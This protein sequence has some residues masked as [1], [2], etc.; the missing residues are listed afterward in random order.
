L[1][2]AIEFFAGR[3]GYSM[4]KTVQQSC[5]V[6][7]EHLG[8]LLDRIEATTDRPAIPGPE[9]TP[10]SSATHVRPEMAEVLLDGPRSS[11]LQVR[12]LNRQNLILDIYIKVFFVVQKQLAKPRQRTFALLL[13]FLVFRSPDLI[14]RFAE[15]L[16]DMKFVMHDF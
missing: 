4:V 2:S 7:L 6:A 16:G 8:N 15:L 1:D 5:K 11:G 12:T 3:I 13:Q 10:A 9:K 14:D